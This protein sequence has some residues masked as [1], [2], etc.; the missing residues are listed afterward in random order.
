GL[1]GTLV[2][3]P[4]PIPHWPRLGAEAGA[5]RSI[6]E[7]AVQ[8]GGR[9]YADVSVPGCASKIANSIELVWNFIAPD[10]GRITRLADVFHK[11]DANI[12]AL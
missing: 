4:A 12:D 9:R 7:H 1:T 8:L 11:V 3:V 6:I 2:Y 5:P 10:P